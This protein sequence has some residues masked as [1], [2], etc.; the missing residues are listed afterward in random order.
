MSPQFQLI[1]QQ[2][3]KAFQCGNLDGAQLILKKAL[4]EDLDSANTIFELG[5]FFAQ[6]NKL[7]EALIIFQCLQL[8]IKGN[9]KI[10]YNLG[11]IYSIQ[12]NHL[13]A[14]NAYDLALKIKPDDVDTLVNKGSTL[15]DAKDYASALVVLN[16]AILLRPNI[17]EAWSN[18]GVALN[19]LKR[20][21]EAITSFEKALSLKPDYA[22][23][24]SNK[25]VALNKLKRYEEAITS[26]EKALSLKPDYAEAWS[27]KGV[28]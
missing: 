6:K 16:N 8:Y 13:D 23:A 21:E 1:L 24:W 2:A 14:L 28:A 26:F 18:K 10:P 12:E 9:E 15:I 4:Q 20:Y 3:I 22:E 19:K 27:N 7:D 25:G 17:P 5:L 11:L